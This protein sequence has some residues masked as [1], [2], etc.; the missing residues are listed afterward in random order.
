MQSARLS[1]TPRPSSISPALAALRTAARR[2][3]VSA[4]GMCDMSPEARLILLCQTLTGR[5]FIFHAAQEAELS[6]DERWLLSLLDA[7]ARADA[8]SYRFLLLSRMSP[9]KASAAHFPLCGLSSQ[10]D[11]RAI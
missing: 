1:Q 2:L 5:R 3:R 4:R 6:F 7:I 10:L 8:A 9:E 11:I